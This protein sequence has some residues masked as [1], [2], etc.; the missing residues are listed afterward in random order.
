M[1]TRPLFKYGLS[2][3]STDYMEIPYGTTA[4]R[5]NPSSRAARAA[6]RVNSQTQLLEWWN[7]TNGGWSSA[8]AELFYPLETIS[9]LNADKEL[10]PNTRYNIQIV[11]GSCALSMDPDKYV[12]GDKVFIKYPDTADFTAYTVRL[13]PVTGKDFS[14]NGT[15][16]STTVSAPSNKS[17]DHTRI[18]S[19]VRYMVIECVGANDF[20]LSYHT[21]YNETL[22]NSFSYRVDVNSSNTNLHPYRLN[23]V[24]TKT[25]WTHANPAS[26]GTAYTVV[27]PNHTQYAPGTPLYVY[28]VDGYGSR[29]LVNIVSNTAGAIVDGEANGPVHFMRDYELIVFYATPSGWESGRSYP[30]NIVVPAP[31]STRPDLTEP[32]Y[33]V[34]GTFTTFNLNCQ[35]IFGHAYMSKYTKA[36]VKAEPYTVLVEGGEKIRPGYFKNKEMHNLQTIKLLKSNRTFSRWIESMTY[37]TSYRCNQNLYGTYKDTSNDGGL[38]QL[39]ASPNTTFVLAASEDVTVWTTEA[40]NSRAHAWENGDEITLINRSGNTIS[41]NSPRI[42]IYDENFEED[43]APKMGHKGMLKLV[44]ED[45]NFIVHSR[46]YYT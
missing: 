15:V 30:E 26:T 22:K 8:G 21:T 4:Q 16:M 45:G 39:M 33:Y 25:G 17:Y 42:K 40:P 44:Y 35:V 9:P 11:S 20:T 24:R 14:L 7:T 1:S 43:P 29:T 19:G 32:K 18:R 10:E 12:T 37:L 23:Y 2:V 36:A 5:G 6:I 31:S 3:R 34:P 13:L 27:L 38:L 41:L 28:D 46:A